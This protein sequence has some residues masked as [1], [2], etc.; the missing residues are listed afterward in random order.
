MYKGPEKSTP[1]LAMGR[2]NSAQN[3]GSGGAG[4][5]GTGFAMNLLQMMQ[6]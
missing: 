5:V 1:V 3:S 2:A 6:P 4:A